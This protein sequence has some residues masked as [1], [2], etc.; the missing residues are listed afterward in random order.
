MLAVWRGRSS[1]SQWQVS[2]T[3]FPAKAYRSWNMTTIGTARRRTPSRPAKRL[4]S[5]AHW[6]ERYGVSMSD[7]HLVNNI[8]HKDIKREPI[9]TGFGRGL[10]EAGRRDERVVAV[11]ADLT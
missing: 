11:C 2:P 3:L 5:C 8:G 1:K 6:A 7:M 10:E 9:R 4:P